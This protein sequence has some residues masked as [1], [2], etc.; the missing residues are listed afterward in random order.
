MKFFAFLSTAATLLLIWALEAKFGDFPRFGE[1]L[2]PG[3]GFWQNAESKNATLT[4]ELKLDGLQGKVIIRFDEHRIPHIFAENDHDLYYV[5]GYL[6][7]KDRLWQMDIQTRAAAGRL[8]EVVGPK[9]IEVDRYH[10]RMGMTYG[11][12]NSLRGMMKDPESK[13]MIEA[14][15]EGV[16]GYIHQLK[17]KDYPIEFKLLDY[18][19]EDWKPI[20]CA[21]LLKNMSETLAGGSDDF[22]MTNDLKVFG[23]ETV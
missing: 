1:F 20:N 19:P 22:A 16:N 6:T 12:E 8:S 10:R 21:Y 23:A 18:A 7:A 5:Q 4:E 3:T 9:A 2:N 17:P 11:A 13:M 15:S 14:Y